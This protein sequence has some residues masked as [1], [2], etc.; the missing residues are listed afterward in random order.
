MELNLGSQSM[1]DF[2]YVPVGINN[3]HRVKTIK[4]II[5]EKKIKSFH[6]QYVMDE[7]CLSIMFYKQHA[8][9]IMISLRIPPLLAQDP[10]IV[11]AVALCFQYCIQ[12]FEESLEELA[13]Y[14]LTIIF[15]SGGNYLNVQRYAKFISSP[16]YARFGLSSRDQFMRCRH[17]QLCHKSSPQTCCFEDA[18]PH[19]QLQIFGALQYLHCFWDVCVNFWLI[20]EFPL[21]IRSFSRYIWATLGPKIDSVGLLSMFDDVC[22]NM[23]SVLYLCWPISWMEFSLYNKNQMGDSP[24]VWFPRELSTLGSTFISVFVSLCAYFSNNNWNILWSDLERYVIL[25]YPAHQWHLILW[26]W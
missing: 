12:T 2:H 5:Y 22:F 3:L 13:V 25:T 18:T 26:L 9:V 21:N 19:G 15:I 11:W 10:I 1:M 16:D 14:F 23:T 20:L 24:I 8:M 6:C 7:Y 17:I 4:S